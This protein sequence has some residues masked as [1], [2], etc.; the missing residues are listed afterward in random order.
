MRVLESKNIQ[1]LENKEITIFGS[2]STCEEFLNFLHGR[3]VCPKKIVIL[4]SF[5]EGFLDSSYGRVAIFKMTSATHIQDLLIIASCQWHEVLETWRNEIPDNFYLL[6]NELM[7]LGNP[8]GQ[9]GPF[10]IENEFKKNGRSIPT[11]ISNAFVDSQSRELHELAFQLRTGMSEKMFYREILEVFNN[12]NGN[13]SKYSTWFGLR[14]FDIVID[15]GIFDGREIPALV[16]LLSKNG[17][18]HGFDP[19]LE[20]INEDVRMWANN[21]PRVRFHNTALWGCESRLP[22]DYE[23]GASSGLRFDEEFESEKKYFVK[24]T[25]L[26]N[27]FG[28][29]KEKKCLIKLD[30]EGAELE[31]LKGGLDFFRRNEVCFA[32]SSYHKAFD[33]IEIPE[34]LL[35]INRK[36]N[37]RIGISNP[38]FIDWVLYAFE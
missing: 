25:A 12:Q 37:F 13:E 4:D 18:Y 27:Y 17:E 35:S 33:I 26:S 6:S 9:L 2:G 24:T 15:G 19:N 8:I 23:K 32:I 28:D 5:K 30:I 29:V 16:E 31:A 20:N 10:R 21:D 7:H 1:Q 14:E 38:T 11:S 3:E 34:F 22:F 36:W